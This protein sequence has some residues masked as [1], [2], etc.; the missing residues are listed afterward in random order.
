MQVVDVPREQACDWPRNEHELTRIRTNRKPTG[1]VERE[2][3]HG[4]ATEG[5]EPDDVRVAPAKMPIPF[6]ATRMEEGDDVTI[7]GIDAR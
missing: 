1:V 3:M 4:R 7:N 6:V 2:H 5:R